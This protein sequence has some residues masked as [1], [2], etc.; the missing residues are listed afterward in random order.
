[1]TQEHAFWSEWV[2]AVKAGVHTQ[3][4][5][6]WIK[7]VRPCSPTLEQVDRLSWTKTC[8]L[9]HPVPPNLKIP[10]FHQLRRPPCPC[11][12]YSTYSNLSQPVSFGCTTCPFPTPLFQIFLGFSLSSHVS[13]KLFRVNSFLENTIMFEKETKKQIS[14]KRPQTTITIHFNRWVYFRTISNAV[15]DG[16][17]AFWSLI[18]ERVMLT[19]DGLVYLK[20]ASIFNSEFK[21]NL[22]DIWSGISEIRLGP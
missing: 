4:R 19:L 18:F 8:P 22:I 5:M 9:F 10:L 21:N 11:S 17:G 1:M 15:V 16:S 3:R 14:T 20:L 12:T 2:C 7:I 6:V 13:K